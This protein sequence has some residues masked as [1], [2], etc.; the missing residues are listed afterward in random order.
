MAADD[1][2]AKGDAIVP[3]DRD[4]LRELS[5]IFMPYA[6]RNLLRRYPERQGSAKFVHY[7]SADAA[8]KIL[9]TKRLWMRNTK[10]MADYAEV[11]HGYQMLWDAKDKL[12]QLTDTLDAIAPHAGK[13]AVDAFDKV[14]ANIRF[15]TYVASFSEHEP[16]D[17][18][19]GKLSMWRAFG[20]NPGGGRVALVFSVP[21]FSGAAESLKVIFSPVAYLKKGDVTAELDSI[22]RTVNERADFLREFQAQTLTG[23]IFAMLL[24]AVTCVKHRG[25]IEEREW[26]VIYSPLIPSM[27]SPLIEEEQLCIHGIPQLV[28]KL[29]IDDRV[30]A[31][32]EID[33]TRLFDHLIIGPT[34]Y[35]MPI[36][37]AC[38]A[39]LERAKIPEPAKKIT[40][41][42]IP[43][44]T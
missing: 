34:Q 13:A 26:R 20:T 21:W 23:M 3:V 2:A 27:H 15:S 19:F 4:R 39:A 33:V 37:H 9:D 24:A 16:E 14:F 18:P 31:A 1:S 41:S 22:I 43:I 6:N 12:R 17:E 40:I 5:S 28:Q 25:F 35:P 29:P 30:P 8:I 11:D 32:A 36:A 10:C 38:I 42:D 7:T 44:R